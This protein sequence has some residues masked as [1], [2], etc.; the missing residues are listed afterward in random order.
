MLAPPSDE[1]EHTMEIVIFCLY[2]LTAPVYY[3]ISCTNVIRA[4]S[5]CLQ[6]SVFSSRRSLWGIVRL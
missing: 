3:S 6:T 5:F 2:A 1:P 4:I